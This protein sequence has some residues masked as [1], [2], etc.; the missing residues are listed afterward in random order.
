MTLLKQ[1]EVEW[2][3]VRESYRTQFKHIPLD[4]LKRIYIDGF[5]RGC[6]IGITEYGKQLLK[7]I[8][9]G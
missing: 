4:I 5:M 7:E 3:K 6:S 1:A 8:Q 2:S 9:N